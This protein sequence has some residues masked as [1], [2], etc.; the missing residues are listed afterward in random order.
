MHELE[1]I[2]EVEKRLFQGKQLCVLRREIAL[3][4]LVEHLAEKYES[5]RQEIGIDVSMLLSGLAPRKQTPIHLV[6]WS[7]N[8]DLNADTLPDTTYSTQP[9]VENGGY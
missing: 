6:S 1:S 8:T 7:H 4:D 3:M 9:I 2:F 5:I